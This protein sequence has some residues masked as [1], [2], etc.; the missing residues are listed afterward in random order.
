M[1]LSQGY[2]VTYVA[3][4][5]A[6]H[7]G[8]S[9]VALVGCDHYFNA[10]GPANKEVEAEAKDKNHFDPNYFADG[11]RWNLPDLPASE[12]YY[13]MADRNY[14]AHGRRIVNATS[15]GHLDIFQRMSLKEWFESRLES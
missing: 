5:L 8:Y 7:M 11:T 10:S 13:S 3:L 2:T 1:S 4:E 14:S 9:D 12:Y 15:G 6:F